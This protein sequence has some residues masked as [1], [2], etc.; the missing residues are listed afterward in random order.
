MRRHLGWIAAAGFAAAILLLGTAWVLS[1]R[2]TWRDVTLRFSEW[3][4]PRCEAPSGQSASR[5]IAWDGGESVG[6]AIPATLRYQP[7]SGDQVS[8]MGDASLI[9]HVH[10][11]QND[12]RLDCRPDRMTPA[13]LDITMPGN[14]RFRIF[15]VASI[16][17]LI[18]KDID[19]PEL[20]FNMAG[21]S[22]VTA[23]GR[24]EVVH[25][26]GA[27]M[28]DAKLGGLAVEDA[29]LN[30]AGASNVE[31]AAAG[32]LN[33]NAVGSVTVILRAEPERI[34]THIMGSAQIIHQSR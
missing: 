6:I 23:T 12:I 27:G 10:I 18:L 34:Q 15:S 13:S 32:N 24:A 19:Q 22:S 11:E 25:I 31:I 1:G 20:H 2:G 26:N 7:G 16:S 9:P 29:H 33:V 28:S 30:L 8:I 4:L 17:R 14:H 5:K 21:S 3:R